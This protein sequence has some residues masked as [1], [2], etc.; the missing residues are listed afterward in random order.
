MR[1]MNKVKLDPAMVRM[2]AAEASTMVR[3]EKPRFDNHERPSSLDRLGKD[4]QVAIGTLLRHYHRDLVE[5]PV[6]EHLQR[7][8]EL[9][10]G[11]DRRTPEDR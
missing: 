6:P 7:L 5:E 8:V 4:F 10:E 3:P 2:R 11:K 9:L 1:L